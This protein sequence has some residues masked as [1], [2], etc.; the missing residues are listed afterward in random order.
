MKLPEY[1]EWDRARRWI[2]KRCKLKWFRRNYCTTVGQDGSWLKLEVYPDGDCA[3]VAGNQKMRDSMSMVHNYDYY[4][5]TSPVNM[6]DFTEPDKRKERFVAPENAMMEHIDSRM[7][8]EG[9]IHWQLSLLAK[10]WWHI[11]WIIER[12][13]ERGPVVDDLLRCGVAKLE[14]FGWIRNGNKKGI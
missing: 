14:D 3:V 4:V 1:E 10:N 12:D 9:S 5:P 6:E 7:M 11:R 8:V 2:G 13:L